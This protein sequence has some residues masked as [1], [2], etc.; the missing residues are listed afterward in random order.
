MNTYLFYV[1]VGVA[2]SSKSAS[3]FGV[4]YIQDI[5]SPKSI[6]KELATGQS[7]PEGKGMSTWTKEGNKRKKPNEPT[8][9]L[10]LIE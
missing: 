1:F 10:P 6:K 4:S 7:I 5:V 3:R 9:E 2:K 8:S